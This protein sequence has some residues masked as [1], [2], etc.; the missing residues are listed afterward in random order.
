MTELFLRAQ[1]SA[2]AL[3]SA[4]WDI[5]VTLDGPLLLEANLTYGTDILQVAYGRGLKSELLG[6]LAA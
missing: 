2:P 5:A 6:A 3:K 1:Q 4:G